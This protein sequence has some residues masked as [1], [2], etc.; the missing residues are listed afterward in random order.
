MQGQDR[1]RREGRRLQT[2]EAFFE[3]GKTFVGIRHGRFMLS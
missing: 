2:C 3:R 1:R